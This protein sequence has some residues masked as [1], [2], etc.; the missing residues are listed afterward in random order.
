MKKI[1]RY[2]KVEELTGLSRV[3]IWRRERAGLFPRR[4]QLGSGSVGWREDEIEKWIESR[5]RVG[6]K[7]EEAAV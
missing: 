6:D 4:V 7:K 1:Y 5:P 3:T 2:R